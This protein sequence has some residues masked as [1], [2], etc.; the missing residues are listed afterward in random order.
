M[1][2]YMGRN[3]DYKNLREYCS[4]RGQK[5]RKYL[6]LWAGGIETMRHKFDKL[7]KL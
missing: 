5:K 4:N 3:G 1:D 6:Y 7:D 2:G